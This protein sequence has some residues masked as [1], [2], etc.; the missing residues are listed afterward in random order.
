MR[1]FMKMTTQTNFCG[2]VVCVPSIPSESP[3]T[4][5]ALKLKLHSPGA[6]FQIW[7]AFRTFAT[8]WPIQACNVITQH[9][10]DVCYV[11]FWETKRVFFNLA[12]PFVDLRVYMQCPR[13]CQLLTRTFSLPLTLMCIHLCS[14]NTHMH[15]YTHACTHERLHS[16]QHTCVH[17]YIQGGYMCV[18]VVMHMCRAC[19]SR[20][21]LA[22]LNQSHV[23]PRWATE[24]VGCSLSVL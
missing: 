16:C 22:H 5:F 23:L 8:A 13:F 10:T 7:R 6:T 17:A 4:S 18:C 20:E 2:D 9:L 12:E 1:Y 24:S 21:L 11:N 15:T 14:L 19:L 3:P